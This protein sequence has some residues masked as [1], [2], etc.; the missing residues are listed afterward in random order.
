[1]PRLTTIAGS[2]CGSGMNC[3]AVK[4][5]DTAPE[6]YIIQGN[7]ITDPEILAELNL[8]ANETAVRIP[9][10]LLGGLH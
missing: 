3:P 7:V 10:S 9:R 6:D 4:T 5:I 1:M 2:E 8:P